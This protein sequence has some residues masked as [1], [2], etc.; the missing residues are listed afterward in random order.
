[1][2]SVICEECNILMD[3]VEGTHDHG[4]LHTQL[5]E[6]HIC[7]MLIEVQSRLK[8]PDGIN[9]VASY[10]DDNCICKAEIINDNCPRHGG[11]VGCVW[12]K[13]IPS[14]VNGDKCDEKE[15]DC[16]SCEFCGYKHLGMCSEEVKT[17]DESISTKKV[18]AQPPW[19]G[20]DDK[21]PIT[22][23]PCTCVLVKDA[24]CLRHG[25]DKCD[26]ECDDTPWLKNVVCDDDSMMCAQERDDDCE[27]EEEPVKCNSVR[28]DYASPEPCYP[29][30]EQIMRAEQEPTIRDLEIKVERLELEQHILELE[31][32]IKYLRE[33]A[34]HR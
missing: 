3:A 5:F 11:E 4:G 34:G 23:L 24:N 12:E 6:C 15:C 27:Q 25:V 22:D 19:Q 26:D 30:P 20:D 29:V 2:I 16:N 31:K 8:I 10:S 1:M 9:R 32:N 7:N 33:I 18:N 28:K 13:P 17:Y 14:F 21:D